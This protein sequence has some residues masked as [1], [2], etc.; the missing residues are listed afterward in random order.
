MGTSL[1]KKKLF[2]WLFGSHPPDISGIKQFDLRAFRH[3][4]YLFYPG[5]FILN[6]LY[7]CSETPWLTLD[8]LSL[9][10]GRINATTL[11]SA[12]DGLSTRYPSGTSQPQLPLCYIC[13]PGPM[14]D[15]IERDLI[16]LGVPKHNIHYEKWWWYRGL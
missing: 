7:S 2:S 9:A 13:G 8:M 6:F 10:E 4:T 11:K 3:K 16:C 5:H 1:Q 12:L 15:D 14:I